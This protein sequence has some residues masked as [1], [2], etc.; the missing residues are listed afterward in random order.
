M[1]QVVGKIEGTGL[2]ELWK[3]VY[4]TDGDSPCVTAYLGAG[5]NA[6]KLLEE[7]D[8]IKRA[9]IINDPKWREHWQR[10]YEADGDA[11]TIMA[12]MKR[13]G[14]Q[15]HKDVGRTAGNRTESV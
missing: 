4:G 9:G 13:Q 6:I 12:N 5:G 15:R 10:V 2:L 11:P 3:C 8:M 7:P 1:I 14:E